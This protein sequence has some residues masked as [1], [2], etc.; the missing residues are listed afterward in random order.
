MDA[1]LRKAS[2]GYD[3]DR[4]SGLLLAPEVVRVGADVFTAWERARAAR[5]GAQAKPVV[6]VTR[7]EELPSEVIA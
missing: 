5:V 6:L 7:S 1:E 4:G 3:E 2:L